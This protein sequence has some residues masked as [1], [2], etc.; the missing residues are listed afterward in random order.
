MRVAFANVGCT[1]YWV[2]TS[3]GLNSESDPG[4]YEC[5]D[6]GEIVED[7]WWANSGFATK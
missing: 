3:T 1:F 6:E 2:K 4:T 5:N 7:H